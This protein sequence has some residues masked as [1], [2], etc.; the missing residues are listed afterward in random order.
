MPGKATKPHQVAR[1]WVVRALIADCCGNVWTL[2]DKM[3]KC[4]EHRG[5]LQKFVDNCGKWAKSWK[6]G[7]NPENMGNIPKPWWN[8]LSKWWNMLNAE[9]WCQCRGKSQHFTINHTIFTIFALVCALFSFS[10][11]SIIFCLLLLFTIIVYYYAT[12]V[13]N[14]HQFTGLVKLTKRL[15]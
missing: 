11:S 6:P 14:Q 10:S 1:T 13:I 5:Q 4:V 2:W 3:W 12:T 7:Q 15:W 8:M 9:K